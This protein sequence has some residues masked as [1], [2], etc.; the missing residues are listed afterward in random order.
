GTLG[1]MVDSEEAM[2]P[3]VRE[4][5][6][7]GLSRADFFEKMETPV[8]YFYTDRPRKVQF[9]VDMPRG[10]LTHWF[11]SVKAFGPKKDTRADPADGSFL[12][13][14]EFEV[15]PDKSSG[16]PPWDKVGKDSTW[17]FVRETDSALVKC[18]FQGETK[19]EK[20]L[21]YRGLGAFEL[22]LEVRSSGP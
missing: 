9:R 7:D 16:K 6:L 13:W 17:K 8:T 18:T 19:A 11:P 10:L 2:P 21:F 1:G 12:D 5:D 20:F 15:V 4:R 3:F 22:P 14:G